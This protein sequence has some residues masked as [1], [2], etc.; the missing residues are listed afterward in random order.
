MGAS[1]AG[2]HNFE[3][4]FRT[5]YDAVYRY[6][7]RRVPAE[8]VQDV[9]SETFLVAWR[10]FEELRGE[11]LPWLLGI[12]RR[13][14]ANQLR[15]R[16]RH[17]ALARRLSA[18]TPARVEGAYRADDPDVLLA[19]AALPERDR[20]ALMLVAW[21]GLDNDAAAAVMRC[22]K[23]TFAVRLH[24]A[25]RRLAQRLAR[26]CEGCID[27]ASEATLAP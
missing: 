2:S 20:E 23:A 11:P 4:V 5:S 10:R 3:Q 22:T 24:R 27:I 12:A 17:E 18:E 8:A 21:D 19:L 13:V 9:V 25:R 16:E 1:P 7:A 15:T 14:C 6:A 26:Q